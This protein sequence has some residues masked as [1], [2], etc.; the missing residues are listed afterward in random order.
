[1]ENQPMSPA[2]PHSRSVPFAVAALLAL[3]ALALPAAAPAA[4]KGTNAKALKHGTLV[5][6]KG[7]RGCIADRSA[8][9]KGCGTAR[10]L[11]GPGPFMGSRAIGVSPDGKN[12]Y[13]ASSRS[14]AIAIFRR[15]T[16]TGALTQPKGAAG[17]VANE[18]TGGCAKAVGLDAPNSIAI[19]PDGKNVYA[20]SRNS[21][22]LTVFQ[23]GKG[24]QLTQLPVGFGCI[25]GLPVPVCASGRALVGPDV[26]VI[27]PDGKNVYVGS[28]FGNAIAVFNRDPAS[29]ALAQAA[30]TT[31][32]LAEAISGCAPALALGAPEGLA[33]SAA[34]TS[35]YAATA[36]S[37]A[38][39]VLSRDPST[40][41]LTQATTGSGCIANATLAGCA[42]GVQ[43]SGANAVAV[44][45]GGSDVYVTSLLSNSVTSFTRAVPAGTLTQ[46]E[47]TAACLIYLRSA[48]CSFGR[49]L[50]GPEGLAVSPDGTNVYVAS[51]RS[52]AIAVLDRS[53][54]T[55]VVTQ[56]PG[57]AGCLTAPK[58]PGCAPGRA[59]RGVSSIAL[60]PDGRY[61][62]STSF[63][64]N[65]VN[66][67]RRNK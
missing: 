5:Q 48:G 67:F 62:Y 33:I 27:S 20:T 13:V 16:S 55:G 50:I 40:G 9:T 65:A 34:G 51:F 38:V 26:L 42:T 24:G 61:V 30:G 18:S 28:F 39:V 35:L 4:P 3:I 60:S 66:I 25:S 23:R 6:L 53:R 46:K 47:A 44:S 43:L 2:F 19:S 54:E 29:G 64:S 17:C 37:N 45:P 52:G 36:L 8:K 56:K 1:M 21:N 31:G 14:D 57:A 41:A 58:T 11:K 15:D 32:C 12:V 22:A 59:L 10:A 7:L 63:G 49:A